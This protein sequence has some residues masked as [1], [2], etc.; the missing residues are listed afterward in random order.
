MEPATGSIGK[1]GVANIT[2]IDPGSVAISKL[3]AMVVK[4][5]VSIMRIGLFYIPLRRVCRGN[6]LE[7]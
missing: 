2:S 3:I 7:G 5:G 4:I 6:C 1:L